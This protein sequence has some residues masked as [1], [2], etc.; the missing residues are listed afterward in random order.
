MKLEAGYRPVL[1]AAVALAVL[2]GTYEAAVRGTL[3]WPEAKTTRPENPPTFTTKVSQ[4][5]AVR[6]EAPASPVASALA[7]SLAQAKKQAASKR[8]GDSLAR[9]YR[10]R[11]RE[12]PPQP[13]RFA[14]TSQPSPRRY[15]G[16]VGGEPA[17]AEIDWSRPDSLHGRFYLWRSGLEHQFS[18]KLPRHP[19][20]LVLAPAAYPVAYQA[21][22]RWQLS[23]AAGPVLQ[24]TWVDSA[25]RHPRPFLLRESYQGGVRY[26]VRHLA[27]SGD[28]PVS[29][30]PC[31]IPLN[32]HDFLHLL[33]AEAARPPLSRVQCPT[34]AGRRR[35]LR[36]DYNPE[37]SNY[38][39]AQVKLNDFGLLSYQLDYADS[40]F[41]GS[42]GFGT[43]NVLLDLVSGRQLTITSQLKPGYQLPLR[44]LLAKRLLAGL[45]LHED[46]YGLDNPKR[47]GWEH[48]TDHGQ[49][50]QLPHLP[51][52]GSGEGTDVGS[53]FSL[54]AQGLQIGGNLRTYLVTI[55]YAELRPLVRPGTP[56]ARML[57]ARGM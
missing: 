23:Q 4:D 21:G 40:P 37:T 39:L 38:Y 6:E 32:R 11:L 41:E 30:S 48:L 1:A 22:G 47:Y 2:A 29:P 49:R 51:A 42:N 53:I 46:D 28:E 45:P 7:D 52:F 8:L 15:V 54:N 9:A 44:R 18:Q 31:D 19:R 56:L 34:W 17:T 5:S 25:G 50:V 13:R 55:P 27:L 43:V 14:E 35:R 26:E 20:V 24:G 3:A 16:T 57:A 36:A 10:D 33:G 12:C